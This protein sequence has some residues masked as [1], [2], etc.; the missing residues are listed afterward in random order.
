MRAGERWFAQPAGI[1]HRKTQK[2]TTAQLM[3]LLKVPSGLSHLAEALQVEVQ[4][5]ANVR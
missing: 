5:G 1:H 3:K 4:T 2:K